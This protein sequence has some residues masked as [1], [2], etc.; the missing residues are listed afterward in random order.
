MNKVELVQKIIQHLEHKRQVTY[1][2][3]QRAVDAATN[4]ETVPEHKYDTLALEAAYLAHGQAM[5]LHENE[6]ELRQY[7]ALSVRSFTD[8]AVSVGAYVELQDEE[9]CEKVFFIG[10]CAGGLKVE[11]E[12]KTVFV[13]TPHSPLGRALMGKRESDE[14]EVNIAGDVHFYE[15]IKVC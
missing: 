15:L 3:T 9:N 6:E 11:H 8:L 5:R 10:P 12:E 4:E 13:L 14:F 7:R 2:S 1:A